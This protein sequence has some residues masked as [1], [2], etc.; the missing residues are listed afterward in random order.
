MAISLNSFTANTK[1]ESAKVNI[2]FAN[3]KSGVE[4][5]AYRA[6]SW[7]FLGDIPVVNTQGMQWIVPQGL[8]LKTLWAKTTSGTCTIRIKNNT[9]ELHAGYDVTS[10]LSSTSTFAVDTT[11][12]GTLVTL[13][14]T[15]AASGVDLFVLLECMVTTIA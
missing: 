15:A 11:T 6:F 4:D 12:S 13:D 9:T 5:A 7:G 3:L 2:N 14:V 8:T 1:A 10:T